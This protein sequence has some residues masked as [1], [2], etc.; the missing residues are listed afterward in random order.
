MAVTLDTLKKTIGKKKAKSMAFSWLADYE[1]MAGDVDNALARVDAGLQLYPGD[2]PGML[3]RTKILFQKGEFDECVK[4]C[5]RI[6][7]RNRS[8]SL[9]RSAWARPTNS[10]VTRTNATSATA[11]ST[12]WTRWIR[13]GRKSTRL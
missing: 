7:L 8:A 5:E 10:W 9:R 2:I 12:I 11:V 1:F 13:S 4:E 3:V 6:L